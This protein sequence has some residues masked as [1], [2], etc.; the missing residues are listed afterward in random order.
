MH[1]WKAALLT[2]C[3]VSILLGSH[4]VMC[5]FAV[6]TF[7]QKQWDVSFP[8]V[9]MQLHQ[10]FLCSVHVESKGKRFMCLSKIITQFYTYVYKEQL[11][12]EMECAV[13]GKPPKG[14]LCRLIG[15]GPACKNRFL[16][17]HCTEDFQI[18][19]HKH[20]PILLR[21]DLSLRQNMH[22]SFRGQKGK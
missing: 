7:W 13:F 10:C 14:D 9:P 18:N 20:F 12:K 15:V 6:A 3:T 11:K 22:I 5:I 17:I 1:W 2:E 19:L 4:T 21:H 16:L 8:A